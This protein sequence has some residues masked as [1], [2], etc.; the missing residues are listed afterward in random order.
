MPAL[1]YGAHFFLVVLFTALSAGA[2]APYERFYPDAT[3]IKDDVLIDTIGVLTIT[4]PGSYTASKPNGGPGNSIF[5]DGELRFVPEYSQLP[6]HAPDNAAAGTLS[7]Q[8]VSPLS[9]YLWMGYLS[10]GTA[11][12]ASLRF[13]I[14]RA[15]G[16]FRQII[17]DPK[18]DSRAWIKISEVTAIISS[19]GLWE[20]KPIREVYFNRPIEGEEQTIFVDLFYLLIDRSRM[21]Y[22]AADATSEHRSLASSTTGQ[23]QAMPNELHITRIS[24]GFALVCIIDPCDEVPLQEVGWIKIRDNQNKL[25][26]W[27]SIP[28]SC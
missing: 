2:D 21:L 27:L 15:T 4:I 28:L 24:N 14:V 9:G 13:P 26:V 7:L 17:V 19:S 6:L 8:D 25:T 22:E 3:E 20:P 10:E 11:S 1:K 5:D 12:T 23:S 18:L 16:D